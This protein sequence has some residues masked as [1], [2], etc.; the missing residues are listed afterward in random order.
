[1]HASE[2]NAI[3]AFKGVVESADPVTLL[4]IAESAADGLDQT[5][6]ARTAASAVATA[7]GYPLVHYRDST[8][9]VMIGFVLDRL[10]DLNVAGYTSGP[11]V[12]NP[13]AN[14]YRYSY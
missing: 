6:K 5:V 9:G 4:L 2:Q 8:Q 14:Y 1:M 10:H 7:L 13:A 11:S 3:L 12:T